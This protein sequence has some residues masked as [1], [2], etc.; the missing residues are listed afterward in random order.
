M[1]EHLRREE[2]IDALDEP[3]AAARQAHLEACGACQAE[4]ASLRGVLREARGVEIDEPSPLFWDHFSQRVHQA[5]AGEPLPR[6]HGWWQ[7]LWRP[8]SVFVAAAGVVVLV[9]VWRP[10][11][12]ESPAGAGG[13]GAQA[14][15]T[16]LSLASDDGS[17]ELVVGL[18]SELDWSDVKEVARPAYGT[19]DA[20]IDELTAAQRGALAKLLQEGMGDLQ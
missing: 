7:A 15:V 20:M 10:L 8:V 4:V 18:A 6:E 2:M 14:P 19:A 3:L 11:P 12:Q 9:A 5:T 13:G 1:T 16:S 17:W